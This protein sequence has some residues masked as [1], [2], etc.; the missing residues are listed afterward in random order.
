MARTLP[1]A[2]AVALVFVC[3]TGTASADVNCYVQEKTSSGFR[4]K[5]DKQLYTGQ[6]AFQNYA[7]TVWSSNDTPLTSVAI[8]SPSG[9]TCAKRDDK[10]FDCSGTVPANSEVVAS[11]TAAGASSPCEISLFGA[12]TYSNFGTE[13]N[14]AIGAFDE[15]TGEPPPP[16]HGTQSQVTCVPKPI[17]VDQTTRCTVTVVDKDASN[18]SRPTTSVAWRSPNSHGVFPGGAKCVLAPVPNTTDKA[19]CSVNY[20]PGAVE[21]GTHVI[22][23]DYAGDGGHLASLSTTKVTVA[24]RPTGTRLS[25]NPDQLGVGDKSTCVVTVADT[26]AGVRSRPPGSVKV[27]DLK[28]TLKKTDKPAKARCKVSYEARTKGPHELTAVYGGDT[29]H[30]GSKGKDTVTAGK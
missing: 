13:E 9:M 10:F 19:R 30:R 1:A 25:C 15:C 7:I 2:F 17:V 5:C 8:S 22:R 3:F 14:P 16:K 18:P 28:G 29:D 20:R 21:S 12:V 6:T 11:L 23:A 4:L 26:G 27:G 24:K